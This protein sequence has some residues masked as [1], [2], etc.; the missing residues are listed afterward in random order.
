MLYR[1]LPAMVRC[2]DLEKR[3]C[4][5][6][7]RDRAIWLSMIGSTD[8]FGYLCNSTELRQGKSPV[9]LI[10]QSCDKSSFVYILK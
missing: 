8:G 1:G 4:N 9:T 2:L 10:T 5:D 6:N 3:E 7:T